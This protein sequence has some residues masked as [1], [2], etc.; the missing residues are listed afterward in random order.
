M[1]LSEEQAKQLLRGDRRRIPDGHPVGWDCSSITDEGWAAQTHVDTVEEVP[2]TGWAADVPE[3]VVTTVPSR[4][5]SSRG[6]LKEP[7]S[8][9]V[10]P[11]VSAAPANDV[12]ASTRDTHLDGMREMLRVMGNVSGSILNSSNKEIILAFS[13]GPFSQGHSGGGPGGSP[14]P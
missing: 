14:G 11:T 5:V 8:S 7:S 1:A 4:S 6:P 9:V 3:E 13:Q 12:E 10:A 2:G